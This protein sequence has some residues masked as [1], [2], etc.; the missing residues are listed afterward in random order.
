MA[1]AFLTPEG[2]KAQVVFRDVSPDA[3][4]RFTTYTIDFDRDGA[5]DIY[6]QQIRRADTSY[7]AKVGAYP[8]HFQNRVL[9][10]PGTGGYVYPDIILNE[11]VLVGPSTGT[12]TAF[13]DCPNN[14]ASMV[15]AEQPTRTVFGNWDSK[16]GFL[17][18]EFQS[19]AGNTHYGWVQLRVDTLGTAI[20]L[21]SY[22]YEA[23]PNTPI[24]TFDSVTVITG[25]EELANGVSVGDIYPNP[26]NGYT[27]SLPII[28]ERAAEAIV[29]VF[30]LYGREVN[31]TNIQ[32]SQG[33]EVFPIELPELVSGVYYLYVRMEDGLV[34]KSFVVD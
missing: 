33:K 26:T 21:K 6:L 16:T 5:S 18:V 14:S 2:S 22:A 19:G 31:S 9:G 28:S 4:I 7:L 17:G 3:Y 11:S 27:I 8:G 15:Y 20:R 12:Y 10:A 23:T 13:Q 32:I 30:D 25:V 34:A 24:A 1:G 29:T